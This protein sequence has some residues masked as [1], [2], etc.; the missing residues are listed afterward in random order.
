MLHL[1]DQRDALAHDRALLG[2]RG[3][4]RGGQRARPAWQRRCGSAGRNRPSHRRRRRAGRTPPPR[5]AR[6]EVLAG[7][8]ILRVRD[9]ALAQ[10]RLDRLGRLFAV[11]GELERDRRQ[12]RLRL[13]EHQRRGDDQIVGGELDV[14]RLHRLDVGQILVGDD[15]QRNGRDVELT[16]FDQVQQA[17]RAARRTR[18]PRRAARLSLSL[19]KHRPAGRTSGTISACEATQALVSRTDAPAVTRLGLEDARRRPARAT[20]ARGRPGASR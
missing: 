11:A 13:E 10:P 5:R 9:Q 18:R 14:E 4:Q 17:G 16:F 8:A 20:R 7:V 1:L 19:S 12:Q 3:A 2:L 6:F 15:R